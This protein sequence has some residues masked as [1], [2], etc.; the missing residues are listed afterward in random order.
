MSTGI[1]TWLPVPAVCSKRW[2][3]YATRG[4]LY[5][6]R[7]RHG[8]SQRKTADENPCP[9][10]RDRRRGRHLNAVAR[11]PPIGDLVSG[12]LRSDLRPPVEHLP[13]TLWRYP[14]LPAPT[15]TGASDVAKTRHPLADSRHPVH[16]PKTSIS[17]QPTCL[18]RSEGRS[19]FSLFAL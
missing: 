3:L 2:T 8:E 4:Y 6:L 16:T 7:E 13:A 1:G 19:S 17:P 15:M 12:V 10:T 18:P 14:R 9:G 5:P 11:D